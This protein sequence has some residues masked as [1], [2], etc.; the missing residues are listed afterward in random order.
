MSVNCSVGLQRVFKLFRT[1]M[2]LKK[3]HLSIVLTPV[4]ND[5]PYLS[6]FRFFNAVDSALKNNKGNLPWCIYCSLLDFNGIQMFATLGQKLAETIH[7]NL[8]W[9]SD[10]SHWHTIYPS[11]ES[12]GVGRM[13]GSTTFCQLSLQPS[14]PSHFEP[15]FRVL[16]KKSFQI[17]SS[18]STALTESTAPATSFAATSS[19]SW[20]GTR[21]LR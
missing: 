13:K 18:A 7:A 6:L 11:R 10:Y 4:L 15:F 14:C 9:T 19:R 8:V 2:K 20:N 1:F 3:F 21:P 17:L 12:Q 5:L 16:L